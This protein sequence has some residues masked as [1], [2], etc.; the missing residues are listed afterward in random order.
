MLIYPFCEAKAVLERC[1]DL[2]ASMPDELTV[3]LG[4]VAGPNGAP[5]VFIVPTWCGLPGRGDALVAPLLGLGTL[6]DN[7]MD[8]VRYGTS[9]AIFD[10][11]IA[12]GQRTFM[13]TCWLP[14]LDSGGI[15]VFIAAMAAAVSPGCAI[16]THE[17]RG[18]AARVAPDAT[19]FGLRRDHVLVE[20]LATVTDRSDEVE[21]ERHRQWARA[22]REAFDG[23]ALP[24]GYPNL[25]VADDPD[26][27]A[28]SYGGNAER[29]VALKQHYDPDNVFRSAIPLPI[30]EDNGR[31]SDHLHDSPSL[32]DSTW[33]PWL[34][35]R[36]NV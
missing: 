35:G 33:D 5:V 29:L 3:Q 7:T 23:M 24:G 31:P 15:D 20:I 14:A 13:E 22:A 2:V 30:N 11:Y 1:A 28:K 17:F 19:A 9:L 4:C 26:R 21:E 8:A 32:H 25:L 10:A 34:T 27:A 18:A 16:F 36:L 6:L 12:N